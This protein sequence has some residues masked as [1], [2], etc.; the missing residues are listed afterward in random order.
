MLHIERREFLVLLGS[1]AIAWPLPA[2][3][4]QPT[5]KNR[6]LGVL[7]PGPRAS[8]TGS[9]MRARLSELGYTEGRNIILETRWAEG[10]PE[11]VPELA[12]ELAGLNLD[13]IIAYTTPVPSLRGERP[14]RLQLSFCSSAIQSGP[15]WFQVLPIPEEMRPA[16]RCWEP[17]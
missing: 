5:L 16:F 6:R 10:M 14:I 8:S 7:L 15:G 3:A 11:R 1:A 17:N 9:A 4:Q 12:G 13:A 2:P